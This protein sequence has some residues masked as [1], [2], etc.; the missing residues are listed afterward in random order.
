VKNNPPDLQ[1]LIATAGGYDRITAQMWAEFDRAMDAYQQARRDELIAEQHY[2][3]DTRP[4]RR[5]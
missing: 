4:R 5:A 3:P 2:R 1:K